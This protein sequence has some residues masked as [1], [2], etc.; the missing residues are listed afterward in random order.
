M[1]ASWRAVRHGCD[2]SGLHSFPAALNAYDP[3]LLLR[4]CS[5]VRDLEPSYPCYQSVIG[6]RPETMPESSHAEGLRDR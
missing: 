5:F 1:G 6:F 2:R 3:S 4:G